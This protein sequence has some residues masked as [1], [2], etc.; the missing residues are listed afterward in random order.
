MCAKAETIEEALKRKPRQEQ[1]KLLVP[2]LGDIEE[3][4]SNGSPDVSREIRH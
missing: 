3:P 2:L 4:C 1:L